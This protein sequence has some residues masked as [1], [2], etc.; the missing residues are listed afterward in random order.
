MLL[1]GIVASSLMLAEASRYRAI[2]IASGLVIAGLV[3]YAICHF[4]EEERAKRQRQLFDE[5]MDGL[6]EEE[7]D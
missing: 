5:E 1:V 2:K 3:G 6:I 7:Y 4:M